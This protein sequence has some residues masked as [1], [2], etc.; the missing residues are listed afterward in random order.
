[1]PRA[2]GMCLFRQVCVS[3]YPTQCHAGLRGCRAS[4]V[5]CLGKSALGQ[6]LFFQLY[7]CHLGWFF[8]LVSCSLATGLNRSLTLIHIL[9][10]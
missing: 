10:F 3:V 9:L 4:G 2:H 8:Q 7:L 6:L 5:W 1:M